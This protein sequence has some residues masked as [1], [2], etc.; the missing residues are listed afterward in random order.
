MTA[1]RAYRSSRNPDCCGAAGSGGGVKPAVPHLGGLTPRVRQD[2]SKSSGRRTPF[3]VATT[4]AGLQSRQAQP[5][6]WIC[7][8]SAESRAPHASACW[9][10]SLLRLRRRIDCNVSP[11]INSVTR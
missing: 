3:G 9:S 4:L 6:E 7:E 2:P 5:A 10:G 11:R 8:M 1:P